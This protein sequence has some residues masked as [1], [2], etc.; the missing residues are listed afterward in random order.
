MRSFAS[1]FTR[2][3]FEIRMGFVVPF[4]CL[5]TGWLFLQSHSDR[6]DNWNVATVLLTW[7]G[8]FGGAI[9]RHLQSCCIKFSLTL[10]PFCAAFLITGTVAQIIALP[11]ERRQRGFRIALWTFGLLGWF[12]GAP[13]SFLHA[14]S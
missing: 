13:V 1:N 5:S 12:A 8:P 14:L 6:R 3:H 9:A 7:T 2:L 4:S 10:F 11:F